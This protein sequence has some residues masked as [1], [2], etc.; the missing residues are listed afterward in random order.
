MHRIIKV[1]EEPILRLH[2]ICSGYHPYRY[3]GVYFVV[4]LEDGGR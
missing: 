4:L 1:G 3:Y 2:N